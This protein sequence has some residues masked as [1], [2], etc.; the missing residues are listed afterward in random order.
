MKLQKTK[1][2]VNDT[3]KIEARLAIIEKGCSARLFDIT[4]IGRAIRKAEIQLS[5][6][7]VTKKHHTGCD[8]EIDTERMPNA[9]RG[10]AEG[11]EVQLKRFPTG[12][13]VTHIHRVPCGR[14]L[15]GGSVGEK[16]VLSESAK[17]AIPVIIHL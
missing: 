12:W 11:T 15:L 3:K 7:G 8:I 6:L 2:N 9:Y 10:T 13:F 16:L 14:A 17:K 1:I 5:Q 4:R